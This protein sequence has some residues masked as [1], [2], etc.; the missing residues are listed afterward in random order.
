[1]QDAPRPHQLLDAV[2]R[3]LRDDALPALVRH[4]E[5]TL[6][7][8]ARVAANMLDTV[9]RQAQQQP[10]DDAAERQRL[11][12]LLAVP[13]DRP[14]AADLAD[15]ADP[16]DLAALNHRLA[17]AIASGSLPADSPAL[18]AHLWATTLAKLAAD[19]PGYD[20]FQRHQPRATS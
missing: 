17:A 10:A 14:Q 15:L 11:Q 20:T 4:G 12:A 13:A 5:G 9:A 3:F 19:Q 1:M 6:A 2:L 16:A 8:Q 18:A 7:Y